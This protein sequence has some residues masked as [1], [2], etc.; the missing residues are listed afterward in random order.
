MKK[1]TIN[2]IKLY[3]LIIFSFAFIIL[4]T[5]IIIQDINE[6]TEL[7]NSVESYCN[8]PYMNVPENQITNSKTFCNEYLDIK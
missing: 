8:S 6:K 7:R 5:I 3:A 1:E 4:G 2:E